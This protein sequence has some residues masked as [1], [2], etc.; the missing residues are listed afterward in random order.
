MKKS[1]ELPDSSLFSFKDEQGSKKP[2]VMV[3]LLRFRERAQYADASVSCSGQ[4][5]P[6][7]N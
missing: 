4:Q 3:N 2:I 6:T 1:V 5:E 7:L